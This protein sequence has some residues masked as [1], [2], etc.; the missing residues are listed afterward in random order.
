MKEKISKAST[1]MLGLLLTFIA[2]VSGASSGVML[3]DASNLPDAGKTTGGDGGNATPPTGIATETAG[4]Q[5]GDPD[6]YTKDIR[7]EVLQ[8]RHPSYQL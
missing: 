5:D 4:R 6:F 8:C 1:W 7:G 3:A 2:L